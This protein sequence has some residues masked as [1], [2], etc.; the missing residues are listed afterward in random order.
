[1][2]MVVVVNAAPAGQQPRR[3]AS[4]Q[5]KEI[6]RMVSSSIAPQ[7]EPRISR[8]LETLRKNLST[9]VRLATSLRNAPVRNEGQISACQQEIDL[10][11]AAIYG[12]VLKEVL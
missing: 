8:D 2:I 12:F 9:F 3:A 6:N 4:Q 11:R 10:L 5:L 1:M 7:V